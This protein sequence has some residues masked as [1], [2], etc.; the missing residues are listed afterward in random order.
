MPFEHV[1]R[2]VDAGFVFKTKMKLRVDQV[3][4]MAEAA[5]E[6]NLDILRLKYAPRT[7][8]LNWTRLC[9]IGAIGIGIG[10][11]I[12]KMRGGDVTKCIHNSE[13][14]LAIAYI[15]GISRWT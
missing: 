8:I 12:G 4:E 7:P 14:I 11:A 13:S 2:S 9:V 5:A 3:E 10:L 1:F 6:H 15:S